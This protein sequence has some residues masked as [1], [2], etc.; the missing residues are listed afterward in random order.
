MTAFWRSDCERF[1]RRDF[2]ALGSAGLVGLTL[3]DYLRW[4]ARADTTAVKKAQAK[5]VIMVWLAGGPA[6]IDMWDLKPDAPETIRGEFKPIP[7]AVPGIQ[8]SEH[9]PKMAQAVRHCTIIRSL[10]HSIPAHGPGTVYM[11]TGNKPTPA[12]NYPALGS[13]AAKLLTTPVGVPPFVSFTNLRGGTAGLAGY[14]GTAY[15]PFEVEGAA[16]GRNAQL[17][18]RGISLPPNFALA[19]LEKRNKLLDDLDGKFKHLDQSSDLV[20]GMDKFQ[21]Q[22][23]DI[24]RSDR[25]KKAFDLSLESEATR[26]RFGQNP[27]GQSALAARRL[28]EA[29]VRFV[30]IG[31]GGWDTHQN[32]FRTLKDQRLPQ[33]DVTLAA[34]V[35][36]LAERGL[37][38]ST[39]VVC[40][41]EFGRTPNVNK[42][43][44]RDHWARSMAAVVAG[45]GFARGL[46]YGATDSDGKAPAADAC[47]PDDLAATIFHCLG[48]DPH[49]ELPTGNGRKVQLFREGKVLTKVLTSAISV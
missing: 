4:S 12:L 14:L 31:T 5:S 49:A 33:L 25:T 26:N 37:L 10:A 6:S 34:L 20:A 9:L 42:N 30:T 45:G 17:R 22:A 38:E 36:D 28:V 15:N 11:T 24:L 13:V 21:Q 43:A 18:V 47:S 1:H 41:G 27:F 2:L 19:D 46:V 39:I 32:N 40:A 35:D 29:G 16:G 48:I 3:P 7:T 23:I 8:I 44:G